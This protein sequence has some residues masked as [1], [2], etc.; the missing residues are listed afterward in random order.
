MSKDHPVKREYVAGIVL[1][2]AMSDEVRELIAEMR[3]DPESEYVRKRAIELTHE[4]VET[5][6]NFYLQIPA[7]E[8]G[9]HAVGIGLLNMVTATV[10]KLT[11]SVGNRLIHRL[12]PEQMNNVADFVEEQLLWQDKDS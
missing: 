9:L 8:L 4:A 12:T 5:N 7:R 10:L 2:K 3:Y 6:L 11:T 1:T